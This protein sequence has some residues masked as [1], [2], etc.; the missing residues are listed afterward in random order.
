MID[1]H[2][3]RAPQPP[4]LRWLLL[5]LLLTIGMPI[6]SIVP[7]YLL[8]EHSYPAEEKIFDPQFADR[9]LGFI[10]YTESLVRDDRFRTCPVSPYVS[11]DPK[12]CAYATRMPVVPWLIAD[13]SRLVG[14][15]TIDVAVAKVILTSLLASIFL[16]ILSLDL[17]LSV[18]RVI[19][20]YGLY[21]RAAGAQ[22]RG[23]AG[24]RGRRAGRPDFLLRHRR[25]IS[26]PAGPYRIDAAP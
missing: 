13:L 10:G 18:G 15:S 17:R 8:I 20:L 3:V 23:I 4:W 24:I 5:L 14:F 16:A 11:C 1:S 2:D 6:L 22:A 19:L 25:V 9:Q 12:A 26:D 21:F 7:K